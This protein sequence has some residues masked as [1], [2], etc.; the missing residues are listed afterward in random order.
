MSFIKGSDL[1]K[2][3]TFQTKKQKIVNMY[4]IKII[5]KGFSISIGRRTCKKR[6]ERP[7]KH[8]L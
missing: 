7:A 8:G 2:L 1:K 5:Q 3:G 6:K 4:W